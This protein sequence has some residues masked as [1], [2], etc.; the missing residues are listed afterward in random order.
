MKFKPQTNT[1]VNTRTV[2]VDGKLTEILETQGFVF[3]KR[4]QEKCRICGKK[5]WSDEI[6]WHF[7]AQHPWD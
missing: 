3:V 7:K 4:T 2:E 1:K 5:V 6:A